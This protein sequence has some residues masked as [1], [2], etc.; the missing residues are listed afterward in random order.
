MKQSIKKLEEVW[1]ADNQKLGLAQNLYHR[2]EDINPD[3]QLY[4]S[5]LEVGDYD[6]GLDFFIPT[7][8]IQGRDKESG[9]TMLSTSKQ[10]VM[11]RTWFRMPDFIAQGKAQKESLAE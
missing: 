5:Y 6:L 2:K 10:Q 9:K 1:T 3:L 7:D 11:K 4:A 8:F